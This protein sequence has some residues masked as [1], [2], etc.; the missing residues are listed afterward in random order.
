MIYRCNNCGRNF[1]LKPDYCDCGNDTFD[2]IVEQI[3]SVELPKEEL[4]LPKLENNC[5]SDKRDLFEEIAFQSQSY[6][7]ASIRI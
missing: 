3:E 7:E 4:T 2:E 1:N 6:S 5:I